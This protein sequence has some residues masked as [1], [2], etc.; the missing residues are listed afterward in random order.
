VRPKLHYHQ[1]G[2]VPA[3]LSGLRI[4]KRTAQYLPLKDLSR[5]QILGLAAVRPWELPSF[6]E[7]RVGDV[8]TRET[9]SPQ[10][11]G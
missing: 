7:P 11:V 3:S 10:R 4:P 2:Y 1:S 5:A 6:G 8:G 9:E